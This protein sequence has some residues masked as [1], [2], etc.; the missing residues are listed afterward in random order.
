MA[1]PWFNNVRSTHQLTIF[2]TD[3]VT[4]GPWGPVFTAA[5]KE[6]NRL[7]S[8][9]QLGV[10]FVPSAVKPDP[11]GMNRG[12][13]VQFDVANG[14]VHEEV[15]KTK[16]GQ[17]IKEFT[18]NVSGTAMHGLTIP[19]QWADENGIAHQFRAYIYVP[20]TPLINSGPAGQQKQREVG[21]GVK[22]FIAVH[23]L[24]HAC[25]LSNGEHSGSD[26]VFVGQ[27][28]PSPGATPQG[29]KLTLRLQPPLKLPLDPPDPP[30]LLSARTA[31][32]IRSVWT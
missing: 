10:T 19:P 32:L 14:T 1:T 18:E 4:K 7:S 21:D 16:F 28:Q 15:L 11:V 2:P 31:G 20:S 3:T 22:L 12:A 27:P 30:L 13:N 6:F 26:D 24:I 25:G 17:I 23:E 29:D 8:S 9:M 5:L